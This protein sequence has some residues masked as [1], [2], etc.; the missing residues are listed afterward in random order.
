MLC[1]VRCVCVACCVRSCIKANGSS[2]RFEGLKES[3]HKD[4]VDKFAQVRQFLLWA[5][6]MC[7]RTCV[8]VE[9]PA[10]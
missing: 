3:D 9:P 7:A 1:C 2:V 5:F 8:L 4:A 10:I 6:R